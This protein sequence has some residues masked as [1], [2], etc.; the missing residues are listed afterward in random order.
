MSGFDADDAALA[1]LEGLPEDEDLES[2]GADPTGLPEDEDLDAL[3]EEFEESRLSGRQ[4]LFVFLTA[5]VSFLVFTIVF[6][7]LEELIRYQLR[8]FEK[9]LA[10]DFAT[11]DLN[12]FGDDVVGGFS[13]QLPDNS[14]GFSAETIKSELSWVDLAA[15]SP[16]GLVQFE[17]SELHMQGFAFDA[18]TMDLTLDIDDANKILTTSQ[19]SI[20]LLAGGVKFTQ[21]PLDGLPIPISLDELNVRRLNLMLNFSN[22]GVDFQDSSLI[23]DLFTARLTGTGRIGGNLGATALQA[24]LCLK[25]VDDLENKNPELFTVYIMGGGAAGGELCADITG[26]VSRPQMNIQRSNSFDFSNPSGPETEGQTDGQTDAGESPEAVPES[27]P[28]DG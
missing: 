2:A 21:L 6:F 22:G 19:G 10:I 7:P 17:D 11:L 13:A 25:P 20:Q 24:T 5:A 16:K 28:E 15:A 23:S 4:K 26:T 3:D 8:S 14:G 9:Q 27:T 12:V 18:A 1:D